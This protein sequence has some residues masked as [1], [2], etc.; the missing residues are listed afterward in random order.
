MSKIM[1]DELLPTSATQLSENPTINEILIKQGAAVVTKRVARQAITDH[2]LS[3]PELQPDYKPEFDTDMGK[4]SAEVANAFTK[5]IRN[6]I[7][8]AML[9]EEVS[10]ESTN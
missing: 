7:Q 4:V 3:L 1:T 2:L 9:A 5:H 8:R 6:A 10:D